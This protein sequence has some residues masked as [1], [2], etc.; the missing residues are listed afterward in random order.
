MKVTDLGGVR[1]LT[2]LVGVMVIASNTA[3]ADERALGTTR[4]TQTES[5]AWSRAATKY[6]FEEV[7][8][9]AIALQES[10]RHRAD[11]QVRPWPWT[12]HSPETGALYFETYEAALEKLTSL[13]A[14]GKTNIDV[15]VMQINWGWNGHRA[16]DPKQLLL[17]AQNIE[18][19]A[20]ILRENLD[21]YGDLGLAIARYHSP[22]TDRGR[23]YA[24]SVL[25]I[26]EY[27]RRAKWVQLALAE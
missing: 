11:G 27:L 7:D 20:Q 24:A 26:L 21:Q 2:C 19:A 14:A 16:A 1:R 23:A 13:L 17:P 12:L 18:I 8:L 5:S 6:G 4:V 3:L 15:G 25:A 10:R 22:R 9:Y